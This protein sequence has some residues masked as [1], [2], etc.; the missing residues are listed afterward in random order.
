MAKNGTKNRF[1][2]PRSRSR[3][4]PNILCAKCGY[5]LHWSRSLTHS[6]SWGLRCAL[7]ATLP[8]MT[9]RVT[10]QAQPNPITNLMSHPVKAHTLSRFVLVIRSIFTSA[11]CFSLST[12]GASPSVGWQFKSNQS[13][14]VPRRERLRRLGLGG[15]EKSL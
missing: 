3:P 10:H 11:Y 2:I 12:R 6:P 5:Y 15:L 13:A 4:S 8:R 14:A 9:Y 7:Y 1:S